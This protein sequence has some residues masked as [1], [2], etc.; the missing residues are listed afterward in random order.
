MGKLACVLT[1]FAQVKQESD[2]SRRRWFEDEA[3]ELI[4]WYRR[5]GTTAGFQLC[6]PGDDRRER[7]LTWREGSGFAHAP[8]ESGDGR[9]DKNLAPV[10]MTDGAVPWGKLA[11]EFAA[12]GANLEHELRALV[13]ER[14]QRRSA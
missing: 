8:V 10:L 3:M 9:P 13:L 7:A 12:R 6:Y 5:D 4:V 11:A 2:G 14:L 1:E